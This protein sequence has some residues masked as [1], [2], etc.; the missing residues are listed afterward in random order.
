M[1]ETWPYAVLVALMAAALAAIVVRSRRRRR[2]TYV[3]TYVTVRP[4]V[5]GPWELAHT[6]AD[7]RA[8]LWTSGV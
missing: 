8:G 4:R 3:G 1:R 2:D 6:T 7:A 5:W